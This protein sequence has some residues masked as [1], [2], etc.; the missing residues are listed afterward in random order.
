MIAD[1]VFDH[2]ITQSFAYSVPGHL[3]VAPGQRVLAPLRRAVRPGLIVGLREADTAGLKPLAA[4]LEPGPIMPA[5]Q[6]DLARWIAAESLSSLGSTC[7]ALLPPAQGVAPLPEARECVRGGPSPSGLPELFVAADRAARV[8]AE[9]RSHAGGTLLLTADIQT[10]GEWADSLASL[11]AVGR[12]DSGVSDRARWRTWNALAAGD[13]GLAVGTRSALLAPVPPPAMLVLVDEHDAAHKPP[14]APR[15]HSREVVLRRA[16]AE[17]MRALLPSATPSV[18]MWWHADS[19]RARLHPADPADWPSVSVADTRGMLRTDPLTPSLARAVRDALALGRR[20]CLLVSRASSTLACDECG[21]VPRCP[22]CGIALSFSRVD[23][24]LC[25][26]LCAHRQAA[27]DTCATCGGR[28]LSPFGWGVERVEHALRRRFPGAR[29]ARHDPGPGR[30]AR[31]AAQRR[32]AADAHIV[33]GTRGALGLFGP[34]SLGLVGFVTPDQLLRIADFRASERAFELMWAAAERVGPDGWVVIQSQNPQH[35]GIRSVVDQDRS[36]FYKH[37][38]RFRAELGYPPFRR[39]CRVGARA[40]SSEDARA[41]AE[42]CLPRLR[43]A[44]LTVYPAVPERRGLA[45][46]ILVK[47]HADLPSRVSASLQ[48][49]GHARGIIE[50]EMDPVD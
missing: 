2:P 17:G 46:R 9:V 36:E 27:P 37:E 40:R 21:S 39:L 28:R 11:G 38:L 33:I 14:G 50:T 43:D 31:R 49:R 19:G 1:V 32:E 41:L 47:G 7:A 35:Y 23:R 16:S 34:R 5:A 3:G 18:E 24:T 29:I 20:V 22:E 10:A 45:W 15:I 8:L 4:V 48:D 30:G 25:C 6:L 12:L 42:W 26:R 44:G 13:L